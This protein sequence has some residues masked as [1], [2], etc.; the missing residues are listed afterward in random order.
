MVDGIVGPATWAALPSYR[1]ASP[2]LEEGSEGP[3]VA[4]LRKALAGKVVLVEFNRIPVRSTASSV[5]KTDAAVRLR[6]LQAW[7]GQAP[8]G[9][10]GDDT[11]SIWRLLAL[12]RS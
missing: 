12:L 1:E 4:W 8:T 11:W 2:E 10:V 6:S 5:P 3:P 9:V 7:A